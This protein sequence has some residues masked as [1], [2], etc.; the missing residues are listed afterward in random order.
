MKKLDCPTKFNAR[1][2]P[3]NGKLL[4]GTQSSVQNN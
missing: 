4:T 1:V 3:T 2:K